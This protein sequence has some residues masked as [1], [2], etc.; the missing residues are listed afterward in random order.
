MRVELVDAGVTTEL[1]RSVLRPRWATGT[2]MSGDD[3][4]QA[5]H[6]AALDD[7]GAAIGACVLFAATCP[8]HP[9]VVPA[10]QLRGMATAD[11]QRGRG[12]GAAVLGAA[13]DAIGER[14]A[15]LI[16]CKARVPALRFYAAHGF[17]VDSDEYLDPET[18]VA[19]RDLSRLL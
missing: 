7:R 18:Q 14:G 12:V 3:D 1:R 17:A 4:P 10:W 8:H 9:D 19:H 13:L 2:P 16:W 5:L 11:G 6:V 15:Q